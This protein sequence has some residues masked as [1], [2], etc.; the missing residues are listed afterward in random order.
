MFWRKKI[1][2]PQIKEFEERIQKRGFL[3]RDARFFRSNIH[4]EDVDEFLSFGKRSGI[5]TIFRHIDRYSHYY[6]Y[7]VKGIIVRTTL[8]T[9][10]EVK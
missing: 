10:V 7:I 9:R 6:Y 3:L 1:P 2:N 8:E 5:G 4:I